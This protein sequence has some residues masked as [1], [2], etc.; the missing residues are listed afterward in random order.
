MSLPA[1]LQSSLWSY[2][3]SKMDLYKN[4]RVIITQILNYG[5]ERQL[6]WLFSNYD[7]ETMRGTLFHPLRGMWHRE[8]LR[9]WLGEFHMMIDP[10]EFESAIVDF[11]PRVK[12]H[13]AFF[14]RKGLVRHDVLSKHIAP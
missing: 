12:L 10:L 11:T 1:Y 13:E 5:N 9:K 6:R 8:K 3:L 2:D 14:Q 4:V 7:T